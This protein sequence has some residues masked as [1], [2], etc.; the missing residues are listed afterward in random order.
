MARFPTKVEEGRNVGADDPSDEAFRFCRGQYFWHT[1]AAIGH[2]AALAV[3]RRARV[4]EGTLRRSCAGP[5]TQDDP[6][7]HPESRSRGCLSVF[8]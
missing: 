6:C 7:I 5:H 4:A 8:G 3:T 2:A 1:R